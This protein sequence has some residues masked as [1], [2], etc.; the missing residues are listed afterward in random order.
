MPKVLA[1]RSA[2]HRARRSEASTR[3]P[4]QPGIGHRA[5]DATDTNFGIS[6]DF[7]G[8]RANFRTAREVTECAVSSPA[9]TYMQ[10]IPAARLLDETPNSF[11]RLNVKAIQMVHTWRIPR[12]K[13]SVPN[14]VF[15]EICGAPV[16][17]SRLGVGGGSSYRPTAKRE[18]AP[19]GRFR[20]S[21]QRQANSAQCRGLAGDCADV[22]PQREPAAQTVEGS[23]RPCGRSLRF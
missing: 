14:G 9:V 10:A 8:A 3:S 15:P 18:N 2:R 4:E 11:A 17:V 20:G 23:R 1:C 22:G 16:R 21:C 19:G 13:K 7:S 6:D 5:C 12:A